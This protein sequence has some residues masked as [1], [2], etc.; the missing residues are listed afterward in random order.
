MKTSLNAA[1]FRAPVSNRNFD[2]LIVLSYVIFSVAVLGVI[3]FSSPET[4]PAASNVAA[5][6]ADFSASIGALQ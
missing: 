2:G 1:R 5:V 6:A 4:P 3:Y